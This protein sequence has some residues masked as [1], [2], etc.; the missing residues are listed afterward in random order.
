MSK[1]HALIVDDNP[2]N[3]DVLTMI[4]ENLG[5][6]AYALVSPKDIPSTLQEMPR[7]DVIF[8]DLEFPNADGFQILAELRQNPTLDPVPIV[9][10][11]VHTSEIDVARR[12]GFDSFIGKPLN[13]ELFPGQL[14][15]I[16]NREA[17]WE[18]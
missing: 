6:V 1:I 11:S 16:L 4:L 3:G 10:Y 12:A 18:V 2:L 7:L 9:A 13:A 14:E 5:V 8:L 15:R 17:V